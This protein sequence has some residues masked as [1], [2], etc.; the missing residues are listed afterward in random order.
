MN[1]IV[2]TASLRHLDRL[3]EI[4]KECFKEEAFGRKQIASLVTDYNSISLI[5]IEE[6]D[7]VGFIIGA[8]TVQRSVLDGH[9][10][11]IDV[12]PRYRCKGV[13]SR[14]LGEIERIFLEGGVNTCHLEVREDNANALRFYEKAGYEKIGKLK[15]YY[16]KADGLYLRKR[17]A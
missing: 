6:N 7:I 3:Y 8:I 15:S 10:L 13:G 1:V 9:V 11:T 2:E 14:L 16:G 12:L 5:A 4:E 17:L